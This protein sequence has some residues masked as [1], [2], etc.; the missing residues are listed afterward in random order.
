[1]INEFLSLQRTPCPFDE[2]SISSFRGQAE[3]NLMSQFLCHLAVNVLCM[4]VLQRCWDWHLTDQEYP[5][6]KFCCFQNAM[7]FAGVV[8]EIALQLQVAISLH[9]RQVPQR[10][11]CHDQ[12]LS[13]AFKAKERGSSLKLCSTCCRLSEGLWSHACALRPL[14]CKAEQATR[15]SRSSRTQRAMANSACIK[16]LEWN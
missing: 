13:K 6:T 14:R 5:R 15:A 2:K 7:N 8:G 1:M 4:C 9:D 10:T 16:G 3:E 12:K 11:H